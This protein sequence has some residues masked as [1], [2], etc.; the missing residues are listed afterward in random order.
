MVR[1]ACLAAST[2]LLLGGAQ[3][4]KADGL[5]DVQQQFVAGNYSGAMN[6]LR[7]LVSQDSGNAA[8]HFWLG[9]CYYEIR[10]YANAVSELE[11]ATQLDPN[12]SPYHDWLGRGYG[13]LAARQKSF[14]LARRVKKEFQ[15]AVQSDGSN[16]DARRDLEEY[17][18]QAPWIVGGSKDDALVQIN[19]I[20][21]V[22][23]VDG[24][25][26]KADYEVAIG[27]P[28]LAV[29]EYDAALSLKP[30]SIEPYLE[31]ANYYGLRGE[32]PQF[33]A[34]VE[35]AAQVNP[36]DPRLSFYRGVALI[37][38]GSNFP[39]AEEDLKAY[40]ASSPERSDW[41]SHS[42]ARYWL[43]QLYEKEG[44]KM[45]AAEQYRDALGLDS[46]NREAKQALSKLEKS[47]R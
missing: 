10:D 6:I 18:L 20:A 23:P 3:G 43:G 42:R 19:A 35:E 31:I 9:R 39:Q 33:T 2:I 22:S 16:L 4:A 5:A 27:K 11:K 14:L 21:Q 32:A 38:G 34:L 47:L 24:H 40:I 28:D 12:S 15:A 13:E 17:L 46:D 26:A 41:P 37:L 36:K 44:N 45:A 8:N 25:L 29:V 7:A 30:Q 1:L